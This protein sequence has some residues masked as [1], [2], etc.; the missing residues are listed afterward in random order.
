MSDE[1][2]WLEE[3]RTPVA[4]ALAN[5]WIRYKESLTSGLGM[6]AIML[7]AMSPEIPKFIQNLDNDPGQQKVIK[8][9]V[10]EVSREINEEPTTQKVLEGLAAINENQETTE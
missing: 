9:F 6:Q 8:E 1:N 4:R 3:L 2:E 7:K 5:L 10:A